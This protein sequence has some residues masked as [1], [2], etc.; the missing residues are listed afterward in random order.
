MDSHRGHHPEAEALAIEAV[1]F[2]EQADGPAVQGDALS[3]LSAVLSAAGQQADAIAALE[4]A[5]D[6]Y[7]RKANAVMANCT[8]ARLAELASS[9]CPRDQAPSS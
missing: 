3:D 1:A 6:R 9:A 7:E 8:Q 5:L 4:R 2:A